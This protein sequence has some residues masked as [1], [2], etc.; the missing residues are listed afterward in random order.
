MIKLVLVLTVIC[1]V[2]AKTQSENGYNGRPYGPYI[3]PMQGYTRIKRVKYSNPPQRFYS[4]P[5]VSFPNKGVFSYTPPPN[6]MMD[7]D[8]PPPYPGNPYPGSSRPKVS[9]RPTNEGLG[10]KD[11]QNFVK[12]LSKQDLDKILEFAGQNR[13]S[14]RYRDPYEKHL[15]YRSTTDEYKSIYNSIQGPEKYSPKPKEDDSKIFSAL[16]QEIDLD[17]KFNPHQQKK[18]NEYNNNIATYDDPRTSDPNPYQ[19]KKPNENYSNLGNFVT[20]PTPLSAFYTDPSNHTN[21]APL[22]TQE[23]MQSQIAY[24]NTQNN[25]ALFT[26]SKVMPEE[27]LPKPLNLRDEQDFDVSFTNNVPTVVKADPS[28]KLENFGDLPLMNYNSKLDTL[29]SYHVPHY[30]VTSSKSLSSNAAPSPSYT[31]PSSYSPSS[32][33]SS[34]SPARVPAVEPAPPSSA[35]KEQSDAHLK[36]VRI[37]S[38]KSKGTAYTLHDDGTLSL[39][40]PGRPRGSYGYP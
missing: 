19:D 7:N 27:N 26:D 8:E 32:S 1:A 22:D 14:E 13:D 30:T 29:S 5:P 4:R 24:T 16:V 31:A 40:K 35:A 38:H 10:E 36:A 33:Y 2:I 20:D 17:P 9:K 21:N 28:Y 15:D 12:Y 11:L 34:S 6:Y 3:Q 18:P 23:S 37:W 25:G 39:E